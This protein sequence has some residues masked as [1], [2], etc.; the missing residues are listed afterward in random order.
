MHE[1]SRKLLVKEN[2][3]NFLKLREETKFSAIS[4]NRIKFQK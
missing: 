3:R 1:V 4:S 2:T